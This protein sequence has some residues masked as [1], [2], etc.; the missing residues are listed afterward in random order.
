M[1]LSHQNELARSGPSQSTQN[2][3]LKVV[4]RLFNPAHSAC[5]HLWHFSHLNHT[6]LERDIEYNSLQYRQ[7]TSFSWPTSEV[8]GVDFARRWRFEPQLDDLLCPFVAGLL[9]TNLRFTDLTLFA[10]ISLFDSCFCNFSRYGL[11]VRTV[12]PSLVFFDRV[13]LERLVQRG[14]GDRSAAFC[15]FTN[16]YFQTEIIMNYQLNLT[17]WIVNNKDWDRLPC[18][19]HHNL[20]CQ[21]K[22]CT[23]S[24]RAVH[25]FQYKLYWK[26][27]TAVPNL[28]LPKILSE[29]ESGLRLHE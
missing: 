17:N 10:F 18:C 24:S 15:A 13:L 14:S 29:P 16:F 8:D 26:P 9:A 20:N 23:R 3:H 27:W 4:W 25:G 22:I 21:I 12:E 7:F 5:A 2:S 1:N 11:L 6:S 19:L 28:K